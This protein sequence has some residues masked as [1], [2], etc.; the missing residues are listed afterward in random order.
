MTAAE[1]DDLGV[2]S[3]E[4]EVGKVCKT[5]GEEKS[6]DDFYANP[7]ALDG[8]FAEC[9]TCVLVSRKKKYQERY[10]GVT[11]LELSRFDRVTKLVKGFLDVKE[12][13][14]DE[15]LGRYILNEQAFKD[16]HGNVVPGCAPA[17]NGF[18][19]V[20]FNSL[21]YFNRPGNRFVAKINKELNSRI[22]EYIKSKSLRAVQVLF[23]IA[24]SD[25]VEPGDRLRAATWLAERVIGKT[26]EVLLMGDAS[27]V[28]ETIFDTSVESGSREAYR[29]SI[30]EDQRE[31][32]RSDSGGGDNNSSEV[33]DVEIEEG[34]EADPLPVGY[35]SEGK[36]EGNGDCGS[37]RN[38]GESTGEPDSENSGLSVNG[39]RRS[40]FKKQKT[41]LV[42]ARQKAKQKRFVA[43][44]L[45]LTSLDR[46]P[47]LLEFSLIRRG[48]MAGKLMCRLVCPS[49]TSEA[50]LAKLEEIN[51]LTDEA[52]KILY[53]ELENESSHV[54][55]EEESKENKKSLESLEN[56]L[57]GASK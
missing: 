46:M 29:K 52:L 45:G 53:P 1:I 51:A 18:Y 14:D 9:K 24:D 6:L 35:G 32:E 19:K 13:S 21:E 23:E 47:Y 57:K 3:Y 7:S 48:A 44:A 2:E 42:R 26:P 17:G 49:E 28:Y 25:M 12:L 40:E 34:L 56:K 30:N 50:R 8:K 5:C 55:G 27:K 10:K 31:L 36:N 43:R 4:A 54:E 15:L 22:N 33:L 41:E 16:G 37:G 38:N 39:E 20:P 11:D